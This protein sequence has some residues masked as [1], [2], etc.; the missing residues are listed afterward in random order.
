M[1]I[2]MSG[3]GVSGQ[4]KLVVMFLLKLSNHYIH[5]M[6]CCV[7]QKIFF[8]VHRLQYAIYEKHSQSSRNSRTAQHDMPGIIVELTGTLVAAV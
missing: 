8:I 2:R 5:Q 1:G 6:E 4:S 3:E 7:N